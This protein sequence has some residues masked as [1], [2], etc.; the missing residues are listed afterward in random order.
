MDFGDAYQDPWI[1]SPDD[2]EQVA[3]EIWL[4]PFHCHSDKSDIYAMA[5]TIFR[6]LC[7]STC[8]FGSFQVDSQ[9]HHHKVLTKKLEWVNNKRKQLANF[10][11]TSAS[12]KFEHLLLSALDDDP[13]KRPTIIEI[14][15]AISNDVLG[16][17]KG[18]SS[19]CRTNNCLV[20]LMLERK[21]IS[22][23]HDLF[24]IL[25]AEKCS[26]VEKIQR[27]FEKNCWGNRKRTMTDDSFARIP[28]K[29]RC[30]VSLCRKKSNILRHH[31]DNRNCT[32]D[33]TCPNCKFLKPFQFS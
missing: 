20:D 30:N 10:G 33:G 29:R 17:G 22:N 25:H 21:R 11:T 13:Q 31:I 27:N 3:V 15:T 6:I 26:K 12:A 8:L 1:M 9:S 28:F 4:N 16:N 19:S 7:L 5:I 18:S 14:E 24:L 32:K 2:A 23:L